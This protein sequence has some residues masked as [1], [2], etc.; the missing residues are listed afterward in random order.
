MPAG[1]GLWHGLAVQNELLLIQLS[2]MGG[3]KHRCQLGEGC[4]V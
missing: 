4:G 3:F 2:L 1:G